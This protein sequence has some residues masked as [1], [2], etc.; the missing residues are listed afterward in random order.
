MSQ[1]EE[2]LRREDGLRRRDG[3]LEESVVRFS[4]YLQENDAKRARALRKAADEKNL[5]A[6]KAAEVLQLVSHETNT[7]APF[8]PAAFRE[9]T[10]RA[11][12]PCRGRKLEA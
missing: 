6:A 8:I 5:C 2:F 11:S 12:L 10:D 1:V 4:K 3:E 9:D 7:M